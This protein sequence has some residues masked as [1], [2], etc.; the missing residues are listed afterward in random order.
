M[1]WG[2][3]PL[4]SG[5]YLVLHASGLNDFGSQLQSSSFLFA[6]VNLAETPAVEEEGEIWNRCCIAVP[7]K[8]QNSNY[9][10]RNFNAV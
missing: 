6:L 2:A 1:A 7:G 5:L 9:I 8:G 10:Y 3:N 4:S